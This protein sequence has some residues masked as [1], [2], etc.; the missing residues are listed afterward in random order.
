MATAYQ[1]SNF[2]GFDFHAPSIETCRKRA[3]EAGVSDRAHFEVATATA[4]SGQFDLICFFDCL[5]D[6]GDPVAWPGTPASTSC[7]AARFCWLSPLPW[8]RAPKNIAEN[9]MAAL[10]Y[11]ASS[12]VC[13]P[14]SL[15]QEGGLALGAQAGESKLREVFKEAGFRHFRR[16]AQTPTN[17]V[18]EVRV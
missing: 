11:V 14:N 18:I 4:Y 1:N 3:D 7:P 2:F 5:H 9:P 15:S 13:T 12:C 16:A 10:F 8:T 6:M 17:L